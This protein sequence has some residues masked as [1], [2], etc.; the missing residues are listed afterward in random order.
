MQRSNF[1]SAASESNF[2]I[3]KNG[4]FCKLLNQ[5]VLKTY[6]LVGTVHVFYYV[7]YL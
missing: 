7:A 6:V 5:A 3:F 1:Q 4:M 2:A